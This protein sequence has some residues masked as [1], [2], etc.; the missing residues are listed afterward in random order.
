M[1]VSK[2]PIFEKLK[3]LFVSKMLRRTE[4]FHQGSSLFTVHSVVSCLVLAFLTDRKVCGLRS[5]SST[6]GACVGL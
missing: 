3:T 1:D 6:V 5:K 2:H 4:T